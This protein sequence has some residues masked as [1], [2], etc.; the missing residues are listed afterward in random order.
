MAGQCFEIEI[1]QVGTHWDIRIPEID[2][3]TEAPTRAAVELVARDCI[4]NQTGIPLGYISVWV[5]D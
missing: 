4:A 3:S 2:A 5:R 1:S